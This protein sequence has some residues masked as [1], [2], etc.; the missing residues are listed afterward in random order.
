MSNSGWELF[1]ALILKKMTDV[2]VRLNL[3]MG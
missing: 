3:A 1:M 2:W